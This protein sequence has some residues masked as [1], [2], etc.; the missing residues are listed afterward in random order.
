[1][2]KNTRIGRSFLKA[3]YLR[4][5]SLRYILNTSIVTRKILDGI[6]K[7]LDAM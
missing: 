6:Q 7:T 2:R 4:S 1:M 5:G 3:L